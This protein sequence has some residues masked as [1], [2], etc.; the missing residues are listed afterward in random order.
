M[1]SVSLLVVWVGA[2]LCYRRI[3]SSPQEEKVPIGFGP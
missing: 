3:L 1:M 2:A